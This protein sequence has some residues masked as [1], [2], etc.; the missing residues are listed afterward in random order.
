MPGW[1]KK[2]N[3][4]VLQEISKITPVAPNAKKGPEKMIRISAFPESLNHAVGSVIASV[5]LGAVCCNGV[6]EPLFLTLPSPLPQQQLIYG[7]VAGKS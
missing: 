7:S 5:D 1:E 4:A 6:M 3:K 2:N